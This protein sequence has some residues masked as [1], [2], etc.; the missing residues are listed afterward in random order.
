MDWKDWRVKVTA[1][2]IGAVLAV[3]AYAAYAAQYQ[4]KVQAT[5]IV[6]TYDSFFA[7]GDNAT[8]AQAFVF[9]SFA[10][11]H[12]IELE[13]RRFGSSGDMK[14]ALVLEKAD[15]V[16][17]VVLGLS[18]L[19]GLV[20]KR[21]GVLAP[22]A[23]NVPLSVLEPGLADALDPE[24]V[25]VP[26]EYSYIALDYD[27]RYLN[28]TAFPEL[29]EFMFEDITA[30]PA[31]ARAFI[32]GSP[33]TSSSGL[34]FFLWNKAYWEKEHP[35]EPWWTWWADLYNATGGD[36]KIAPGWSEA[37]N[38]FYERAEGPDYH[39]LVSYATDPAYGFS[40]AGEAPWFG[41]TLVH[42]STGGILGWREI[43]G[44]AVVNGTEHRELAE[45]FLRWM[46]S[47]AVQNLIPMNEWVYPANRIVGGFVE[48][49]YSIDPSNVIPLNE[50]IS[51]ELI[52]TSLRDW[53]ETWL[54]VI[55]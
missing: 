2:A 21:E 19:N 44:M 26:F 5:L 6:Y 41:T 31:L 49:P 54:E 4:R 24:H 13:V 12:R 30:N 48:F 35:D 17:D 32:S 22:G 34:S 11:S 14:N 16:A 52:A 51:P 9:D 53:L 7:Y 1:I 23:P 43:Q 20:A 25:L 46:L 50:W 28:E 3:A 8:A 45:T 18:N 37:F 29:G 27:L 15:P 47:N 40:F 10:E 36:I 38:L 33:E 55:T 42:N 39:L